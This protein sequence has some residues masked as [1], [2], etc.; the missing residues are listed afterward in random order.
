MLQS[1]EDISMTFRALPFLALIFFAGCGGSVHELTAI[2]QM[3]LDPALQRLIMGSGIDPVDYDISRA[4][5]GDLKYGVIVH[6]TDVEELKGA[7][8]NVTSN[9]DGVMVV[10]VTVDELRGLVA[11]PSVKAVSAGSKFRTQ[12]PLRPQNGGSKH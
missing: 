3:K 6:S 2:E 12:Q 1:L 7:G 10:R 8:Y 4:P 5:N 11:L 9:F